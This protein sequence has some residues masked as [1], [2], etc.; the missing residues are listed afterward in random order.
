VS[1]RKQI[2]DRNARLKADLAPGGGP[3]VHLTPA[4]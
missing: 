3:A 1:T 4:P 2:A